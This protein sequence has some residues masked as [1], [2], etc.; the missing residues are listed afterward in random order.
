MKW[1][2]IATLVLLASVLIAHLGKQMMENTKD[3][4]MLRK[5]NEK[6]HDVAERYYGKSRYKP[7][8]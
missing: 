4:E 1:L 8:P 7:G 2:R 6:M 5:A 3:R